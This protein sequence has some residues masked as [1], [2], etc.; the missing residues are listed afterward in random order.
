[1]AKKGALGKG[2]SALIPEDNGVIEKAREASIEV[3]ID[4]VFPNK[5]QPRHDFDEEK[6]ESLAQSIKEHGIIQPIIVK[7]EGDFYKIIAGERRWRAS[8]KIGMKKIPIIERDFSEREIAEISL[9]ENIQR[10]D[11]NPIEEALAYKRLSKEFNLTQEEIST[12]VG[13]S[14]A[15]ITNTMRLLTLHDDII[16]LIEK[17][18]LTEGHGKIIA[19]IEDKDI[20]LK[21]ADKVIKEELNVRQTETLIRE[22][23]LD[24]STKKVE[25]AKDIHVKHVEERLKEILG[26][27]V[28]INQGKKKGKLEIEFYSDADLNRI[29]DLISK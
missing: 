24:K 19:G 3:N 7:K 29:L 1:M 22:I 26:T 8:K 4:D 17:R 15:A 11:L 10:E 2:L 28:S 27:K 13:K 25:K 5:L 6:I 12:R 14:R 23:N 20:Q 21:I 18:S 16:N 9:I